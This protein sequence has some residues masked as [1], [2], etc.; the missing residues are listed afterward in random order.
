MYTLTDYV[1]R[2][3]LLLNNTF[4]SHNKKLSTVMIYATNKCNARCKH[5]Y[6]W[7]K[8]PKQSLSVEIVE[9]I[10]S[11]IA[12]TSKTRIGL[13]GG[14]FLLHDKYEEILKLF[15]QKHP[16]FDLLSNCMLPEKLIEVVKKHLLPLRHK[17]W[18]PRLYISLDG[19]KT[20]HENLRGIKGIYENV[21]KVIESLHS[22]VPM[23]VMFTLTPFNT[24]SDLQHVAE[25]CKKYN[26]DLRIGIYNNMQYFETKVPSATNNSS[27]NYAINDIPESVKDFEENYNF[28]LLHHHYRRGNLSLS[29]NSIKDSIVV[30]PNGDVPLCQHKEI[31]LGNLHSESLHQIIN[32]KNTRQLHQQ[33][34]KC[35]DCWINF[36]RKYDIVLYRNL[37][38]IFGKKTVEMVFGKY[39]WCGDALLNYKSVLKNKL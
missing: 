2:G 35:N 37:E 13:E 6:I 34:R 29:C 27:L 8:K 11:D 31:V 3:S 19:D 5:C 7:E 21:L 30:Y 1:H 14:E 32:K 33:Y 17:K 18:P 10:I 38:N 16:S 22:F 36:H 9:K 39:N 28:M 24:M 4:F 23:S 20:V 12:I 25:I 15:K 26:L